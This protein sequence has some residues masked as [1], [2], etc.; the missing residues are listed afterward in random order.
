MQCSHTVSRDRQQGSRGPPGH[1]TQPAGWP[2]AY[3][4]GLSTPLSAEA[5]PASHCSAS[6]V[7][8]LSSSEHSLASSPTASCSLRS[9]ARYLLSTWQFLAWR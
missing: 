9:P 1:D 2:L 4:M 8:C 3:L 6:W 7:S 5:S